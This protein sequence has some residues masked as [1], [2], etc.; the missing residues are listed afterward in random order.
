MIVATVSRIV[1]CV[2][3]SCLAKSQSPRPDDT[4]NDVKSLQLHT[5]KITRNNVFGTESSDFYN[6]KQKETKF[7]DIL[8]IFTC[9][10]PMETHGKCSALHCRTLNTESMQLKHLWIQWQLK[11]LGGLSL[12]ALHIQRQLKLS[13]IGWRAFSGL[14]SD[15]WLDSDLDFE[16]AILTYEYVR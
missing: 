4:C 15:S 7:C 2:S 12:P 3:K 14:S 11:S 5:Y 6:V 8:I 16:W 9:R 10:R 13:Q 1:S